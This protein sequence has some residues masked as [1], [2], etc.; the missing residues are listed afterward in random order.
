MNTPLQ[1]SFHNVPRSE[2]IETAIREAAARLEGSYDR[3]MSCRVIVDQPH[4]HQKEGSPYQVRIDL[5]VPGAEL[6]VK[7]EPAEHLTLAELDT[8]IH[9]AF[10]DMQ[11]QLDEFLNRRRGYVR[12]HQPPPHAR[13]TRLFRRPA[14]VPSRRSMAARFS[15]LAT[16]S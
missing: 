15:S 12:A 9:E 3:I 4:R 7:R 10:D 6:V 2:L 1:F 11:R 5:K 8:V 14:Q 13:V 16:G